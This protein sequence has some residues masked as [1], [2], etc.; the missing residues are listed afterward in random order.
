MARKVGIWSRNL[1]TIYSAPAAGWT[2]GCRAIAAT[3]GLMVA[4]FAVVGF[5]GFAACANPDGGGEEHGCEKGSGDFH[6]FELNALFENV[7]S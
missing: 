2:I 1:Q 6:E 5:G 7:L 3:M 4:F